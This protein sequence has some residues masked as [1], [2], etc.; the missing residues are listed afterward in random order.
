MQ[1]VKRW[2]AGKERSGSRLSTQSHHRQGYRPDTVSTRCHEHPHKSPDRQMQQSNST[3]IPHSRGPQGSPGMSLWPQMLP[4][5]APATTDYSGC[6]LTRICHVYLKTT[7]SGCEYIMKQGGQ[8]VFC[9]VLP[10]CAALSTQHMFRLQRA[11]CGRFTGRYS[12]FTMLTLKRW[13]FCAIQFFQAIL[14]VLNEYSS[15]LPQDIHFLISFRIFV[16]FP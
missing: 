9:F 5:G 4:L 11:V 16:S 12:C 10:G 15:N 6:R 2:V 14:A 7:C 1:G 8:A 13:T 3:L